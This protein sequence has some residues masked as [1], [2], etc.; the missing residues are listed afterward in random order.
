MVERSLI[1][2]TQW[3]ALK[4]SLLAFIRQHGDRRITIAALQR[5]QALDAASLAREAG[6]AIVIA[7]ASRGTDGTLLGV[8]AR[9]GEPAIIGVAAAIR[10]GADACVAIVKPQWRSRGIG[11]AMMRELAAAVPPLCCA[12]AEDNAPSM[13]MCANAGFAPL[14]KFTGPTG[15]PTWRL[16]AITAAGQAGKA[17]ADRRDGLWQNLSSAY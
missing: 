7:R 6:T 9:T 4:P 17:A 5:L 3:E 13:R 1:E 11:S 12:V 15:K 8:E 14:E 10:H 2:Q 16:T